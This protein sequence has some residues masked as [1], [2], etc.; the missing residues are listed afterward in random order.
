MYETTV[1]ELTSDA[2]KPYGRF[3]CL[4]DP[5][6][7]QLG[8]KPT[9]WYPDI[10]N[11]RVADNNPQFSICK[12][13]PREFVVTVAEYHDRT[14]EGILP[15]DGDV[16]IHV[17]KPS[18]PSDCPSEAF[19]VFKVPRGTMV[20]LK[21]GVW[22]HAPYTLSE[23]PVNVVIVLPERTYAVDCILVELPES[24]RVKIKFS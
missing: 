22:H 8:Q 6:T 4:I 15:L 5:E 2:F 10:T 13:F 20:T 9:E 19:E 18:N 24:K 21:P 11:V 23:K 17:G 14:E 1:R 12:A 3:A 7:N 16:L